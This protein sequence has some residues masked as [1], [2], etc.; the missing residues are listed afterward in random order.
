MTDNRGIRKINKRFLKHD[1]A[2][3]VI[4]FNYGEMADI[5]VSVE[6]AKKVAKE[7]GISFKEELARYLIHGVLHIL[8]YD[9]KSFAK[10]K[11]M[12]ARQE[13]IL[14]VML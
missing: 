12:H 4:A 10:R 8:G 5:V 2:T 1:Y 13:E 9:D 3:D 7:L 14:K 11:I 6:M